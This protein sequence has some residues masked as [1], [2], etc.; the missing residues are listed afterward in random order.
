[1]RILITGGAVHT[2]LDAVKII[3]N[4][5]CGKRIA[6]LAQQLERRGHDITYLCSKFSAK[7][8]DSFIIHDGFIDYMSKVVDLCQTHDMF[9]SGAAV[10]NLV[11]EPP[12]DVRSK[13]P[14]HEYQEGDVVNVPFRVAPR[15]INEV[16]Q[17]NPRCIV[18]GFK[19]L[20]DVSDTELVRAAYTVIR[21]A[22]ADLV[23]ANDSED[24]D[25]KLLVTKERSVIEISEEGYC[26]LDTRVGLLLKLVDFLDALARDE[27][28][29]TAVL[30]TYEVPAGQ[31]VGAVAR[32][33]K[34]AIERYA[35]VRERY[36]PR[37]RQ[38]GLQDD[39]L[40]GCI[41]VRSV[42][43]GFIC[44]A[45]G[46]KDLSEFVHV[47]EVEHAS[48]RVYAIQKKASLNAPLLDSLFRHF[49]M[50][51]AIVHKH[52]C[53]TDLPKLPWA[54]PG[55]ARD[56]QREL[57]SGDFEIEHHGTFNILTEIP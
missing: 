36:E 2:K 52:E 40:F 3:T 51:Q 54:P 46:K 35:R 1:M 26:D 8:S 47:A 11:P 55:T 38:Y 45:R 39:L 24:L 49:P 41:A 14:S 53:G 50:A 18:V 22:K 31:P 15:V 34:T 20:S 9:I 37:L 33:M 19:L 7:P 56:S 42:N 30:H 23:I 28:Y 10:A 29:S 13:F 17:V 57:P 16:K 32:I 4:R 6:E 25:R 5:Y 12:W 48:R 44:S 43:N 21:E 27:Y